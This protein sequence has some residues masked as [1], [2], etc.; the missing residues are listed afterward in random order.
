VVVFTRKNAPLC[1]AIFASQAEA[2]Q[3][4]LLEMPWNECTSPESFISSLFHN[5]SGTDEKKQRGARENRTAF[6]G[7]MS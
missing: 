5:F 1:K 4:I 6:D 3:K 2:R 7:G